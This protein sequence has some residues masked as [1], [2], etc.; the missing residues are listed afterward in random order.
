MG[1]SYSH[2]L[3]RSFIYIWIFN[4]LGRL[5]FISVFHKNFVRSKSDHV[6][7]PM[8]FSTWRFSKLA[9]YFAFLFTRS[10][11]SRTY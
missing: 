9:Y 5:Y 2:H 7:L 8:G 1:N 4:I 11:S 10:E 3:G 6:A